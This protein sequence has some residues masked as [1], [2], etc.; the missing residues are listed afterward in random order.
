MLY[1]Q[2]RI[3]LITGRYCSKAVW[4]D[5]RRQLMEEMK[6]KGLFSYP[7]LIGYAKRW[8]YVFKA[9]SSTFLNP[10]PDRSYKK[11][12]DGLRIVEWYMDAAAWYV[13]TGAWLRGLITRGFY[14]AHLA[15]S[16]LA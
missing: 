7:L 10:W 1:S 12:Y 11:L 9:Y 8:W 14:G 6:E 16:G 3:F 15:A 2:I 5:N 4:Q 13:K